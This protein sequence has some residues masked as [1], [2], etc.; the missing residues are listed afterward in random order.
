MKSHKVGGGEGLWSTGGS[1][2][3]R[4]LWIAALVNGV[5]RSI[6]TVETGATKQLKGTFK[7][8][9]FHPDND[10]VWGGAERWHN[11]GSPSC[12]TCKLGILILGSC[13]AKGLKSLCL[14]RASISLNFSQSE[15]TSL[16]NKRT[17]RREAAGTDSPARCL[18]R[19]TDIVQS[20]VGIGPKQT[21]WEMPF[22]R[23]L[24]GVGRLEWTGVLYRL[25]YS[26]KALLLFGI[27]NGIC[28]LT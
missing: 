9:R 5:T 11:P 26:L 17:R 20:Q 16:R 27:G 23:H 19:K 10:D 3:P 28:L 14:S 12:L 6:D 1:P 22:Q 18:V 24:W 8:L 25:S 2:S 13:W 4:A 15:E 7:S 21:R